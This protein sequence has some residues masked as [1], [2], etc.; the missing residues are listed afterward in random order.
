METIE[1]V[2]HLSK[3]MQ[4]WYKDIVIN[5]DLESYDIKRLLVACESWDRLQ[6]VKEILKK[7]GVSIRDRFGQ[8]KAHP[9]LS[10]ERDLNSTFLKAIKDMGLDI[11]PP[12]AIGRPPGR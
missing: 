3:E 4:K 12:G 8:V 7:D 10:T 1:N 6:E 5:F 2:R 9:L 11:E